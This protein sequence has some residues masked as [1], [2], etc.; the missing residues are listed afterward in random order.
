MRETIFFFSF[1]SFIFDLL[2]VAYIESLVYPA[3]ELELE[4]PYK[5][6]WQVQYVVYSTRNAQPLTI[7]HG[8]GA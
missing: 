1:I 4:L 6:S 7:P 2:C 5:T 8:Y 3:S